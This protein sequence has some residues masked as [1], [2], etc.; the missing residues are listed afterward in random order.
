VFGLYAIGS[1]LRALVRHI[2]RQ[3]YTAHR[4]A[5]PWRFA[6]VA[7]ALV[8]LAPLVVALLVLTHAGDDTAADKVR[9]ALSAGLALLLMGAFAGATLPVFSV[10]A[11]RRGWWSVRARLAYTALALAAAVAIPLLGWYRLLGFWM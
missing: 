8:A 6:R 1:T 3:P 5:T 2:R 10:L 9:F 7:A 11:W 4:P